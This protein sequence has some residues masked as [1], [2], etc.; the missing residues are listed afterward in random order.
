MSSTIAPSDLEAK[1][2]K[3]LESPEFVARLKKTLEGPEFRSH[4]EE[5]LTD[6]LRWHV[7]LSPE[8]YELISRL[9]AETGEDMGDVLARALAL[10]KVA[11]DARKQGKQ[12]GI[13]AKGQPIETVINV[14]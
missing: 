2:T 14:F 5:A 1:I 13:A 10:L 11:D 9:A 3:I 6:R 8:A 12:I 7:E 4:L